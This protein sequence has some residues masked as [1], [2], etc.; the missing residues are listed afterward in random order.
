MGKRTKR[1]EATKTPDIKLAHPANYEDADGN[2]VCIYAGRHFT[3]YRNA[4]GRVRIEHH[5]PAR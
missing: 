4:G 3:E 1:I 2:P 5:R